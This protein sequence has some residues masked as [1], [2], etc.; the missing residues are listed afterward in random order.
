[1]YDF[2]SNFI[3]L[4]HGF[5]LRDII[6]NGRY[7]HPQSGKPKNKIWAGLDYQNP[8]TLMTA[9]EEKLMWQRFGL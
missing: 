7:I 1:M 3:L 8:E 6:F 5:K 9:M 4:N 2:D